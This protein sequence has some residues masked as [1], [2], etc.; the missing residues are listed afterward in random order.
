MASNSLSA[1]I[2]QAFLDG[3]NVSQPWLQF[4]GT[5]DAKK[6]QWT[7]DFSGVTGTPSIVAS[8]LVSGP[9]VRLYCSFSGTTSATSATC[10][11]PYLMDNIGSAEF[12]NLGTKTL[13]GTGLI[14][15]NQINFPNWSGIANVSFIANYTGK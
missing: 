10:V 5:I 2:Q 13:I 15:G 14:E 3:G 8:S 9:F 4:F 11:L 1:V 6:K 12:W 7:P